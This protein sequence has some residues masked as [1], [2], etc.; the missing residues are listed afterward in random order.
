MRIIVFLCD[1]FLPL[2]K[3]T[4]ATSDSDLPHDSQVRMV[5]D[6]FGVT[7]V[8]NAWYD[9]NQ[10]TEHVIQGYTKVITFNS[11]AFSFVFDFGGA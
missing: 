4:C 7:A 2:F 8:R 1:I 3:D 5:I 6:K 11:F 10:V 9:A